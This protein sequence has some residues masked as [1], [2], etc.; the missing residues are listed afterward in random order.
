MQACARRPPAWACRNA[1]QRQRRA[2]KEVSGHSLLLCA[3]PVS[4]LPALACF[5]R[6]PV[7]SA[8]SY[9][10]G[11]QGGGQNK[12]AAVSGLLRFTVRRTRQAY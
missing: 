7:V 8:V 5:C 2:G 1:G 3:P 11:T 10:D 9:F 12:D 4:V 6:R